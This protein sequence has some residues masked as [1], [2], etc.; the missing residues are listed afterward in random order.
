MKEESQNQ[1]NMKNREWDPHL[2]QGRSPEHM[3]RNY[4]VSEWTLWLGIITISAAFIYS[5]LK[6]LLSNGS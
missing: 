3:E 6:D 5:I 4:K 1:Q 2:T